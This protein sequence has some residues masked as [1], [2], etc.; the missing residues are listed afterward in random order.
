MPTL[1]C[2]H[3]F[4]LLKRKYIIGLLNCPLTC[5]RY[6]ETWRH[7]CLAAQ[8]S[9][10]AYTR[11][12]DAEKETHISADWRHGTK[13]MVL[14]SVPIDDMNTVVLAI[15]GSQT[16]MD[17]AVNF[18]PAP[19]S[20]IGFLDDPGN[21]CHSG[22]LTV[23]RAMVKPVAARLRQ[24]LEQDPSRASWSLLITGHS[25]G[26]AVAS[27]IYM[28]MLSETMESELNILTGCFKRIHCITFGT[29]PVSLLPLQTP[30]KQRLKKSM[31]F[32]FINQ[33]DPVVRANKEYV[34]SLIKLYTNP[35]P[36]TKPLTNAI[37]AVVPHGKIGKKPSKQQLQSVAPL[38][39]WKVPPTTLSNAGRLVLIREKPA[40]RG[41]ENIEA[42][43][44]SDEQ[45]RAVIFGDPM[46]HMMKVYARRVELL[47]TL[48][49]T[50]RM[51][52]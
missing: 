2:R 10:R 23:A 50:G 9:E 40:I 24:L 13:A 46:V 29:P 22:F 51:N 4:Y 26:G 14:K 52:G 11:P 27:L 19:S 45:L 49:V 32:S 38:P 6:I 5:S 17:W 44:I 41:Q 39:V 21:L 43:T 18:R 1:D 48:A 42:C 3:P 33:G 8:Y 7:V 16:F 25:A 34:K 47:A 37:Q 31:F 12:N 20:P 28:H 35:L 36:V 15:R 30:S